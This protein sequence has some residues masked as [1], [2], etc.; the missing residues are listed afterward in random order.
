MRRVTRVVAIACL[1]AAAGFAQESSGGEGSSGNL[2]LWKWANF[3]V[4][5]GAIGYLVGKNAPVFFAARSL[6]IRKEIVEAEEA[7]KD[8]EARA[9]AVD[10]R[11]ANLEAEI[12]GAAAVDQRLANLEA[13]IAALR[14]EAHDEARAETAR[15]A[16]HT[17]AELAKIQMHAEQ[18]IA[19]AGKAARMELKRYAA[20]LA[21]ELAAR[22][23]R[24]RMTPATQDALVRGFV[25][26]L[27]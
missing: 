1:V 20:D 27:K 12:A 2:E 25:R 6:K 15:A 14:T 4:L 24:A 8:A 7:R 13:E 5:A 11:L 22:K 10:Q 26:D 19:S 16:Q 3:L 23:I 18:E 21:I 9:A 17:A